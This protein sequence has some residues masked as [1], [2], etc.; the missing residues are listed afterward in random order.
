MIALVFV[1]PID[2]TPL[3]DVPVPAVRAR[4]PP[5]EVVPVSLPPLIFNSAPV[6]EFVVFAPGRMV[7]LV[8]LVPVAVVKS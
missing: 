1:V 5:V 6:P 4:P 8:G 3:V 2:I 7:S